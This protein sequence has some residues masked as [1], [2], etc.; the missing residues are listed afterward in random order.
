MSEKDVVLAFWQA[1]ERNDFHAVGEWLSDDFELYWPQS[2]ELIQGR[3][4]F[5]ALNSAYPAEGLW[6]FTINSLVHEREQ[7]VTDVS[8][9]D[10]TRQDRAITFHTVRDGKICRQTEYWP[11]PFQAPEWRKQWVVQK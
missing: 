8:V 6:R 9:T 1:M 4:N 11:D 3:E 7:V 2:G 10:G 5:G